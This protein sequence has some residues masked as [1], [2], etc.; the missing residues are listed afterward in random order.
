MAADDERRAY[1]R[2]Y[3]AGS[4][5]RWPDHKPPAPPDPVVAELLAAMAALRDEV[6]R[7]L[8]VLDPDDPWERDL[9]PKVDA[10]DEAAKK[11][12]TWLRGREE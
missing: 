5:R 3:Y 12:T 9:G 4:Y 10:C 11:V 1:Q 6:D 7:A 8:A 2:G